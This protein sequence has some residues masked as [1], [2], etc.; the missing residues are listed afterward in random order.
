MTWDNESGPGGAGNTG[1]SLTHS[2][3]E[4][5][6]G[7]A[8]NATRKLCKITDCGNEFHAKELCKRHYQQQWMTGSPEII[9]PNT[10]GTPVDR[11]WAKVPSRIDGECWE[12]A[13]QKDKDG[14]GMLRVGDSPVR[15]HRLSYELAN[16]P[17]EDLVRHSCNNPPCVNP[18]H[19]LTG[20][21][22]DNMDDRMEAG[23]YTYATCRR[24]HKWTDATTTW[25]GP[26]R[27]HRT[28]KIC[29]RMTPAERKLFDLAETA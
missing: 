10:H 8:M 22:Q 9:R 25:Q 15:S 16:G 11:F 27:K 18:G 5:K 26:G 7:L 20:D 17:T 2:L 6:E 12:W 1:R 19:L 21:H 29:R 14:Y 24:G 23:N 4:T 28:C 13:G 3:D